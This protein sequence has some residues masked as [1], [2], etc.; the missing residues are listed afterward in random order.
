[1]AIAIGQKVSADK[2]VVKNR[3]RI[4]DMDHKVAWVEGPGVSSA[5]YLGTVLVYE[6]QTRTDYGDNESGM[7]RY[8]EPS[9]KIKAV[10]LQPID[11]G[12]RYRLPLYALPED[13]KVIP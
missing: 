3:V 2:T 13:V 5:I 8:F 12:G 6:G 9:T 1:M 10:V 4:T 11:I 7:F